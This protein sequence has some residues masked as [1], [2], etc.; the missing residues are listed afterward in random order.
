M[1]DSSLGLLLS[2]F[3]AGLLLSVIASVVLVVLVWRKGQ[4]DDFEQ[5]LEYRLRNGNSGIQYRSWE[6][7]DNWGKWVIGGYQADLAEGE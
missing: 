5:K 2:L 3:S 1:G 7:P 4:L 6:E